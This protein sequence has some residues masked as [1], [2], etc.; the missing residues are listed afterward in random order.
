MEVNDYQIFLS[1]ASKI[2]LAL[3]TIL[4]LKGFFIQKKTFKIFN[5]YLFVCL[6]IQVKSYL[7][8]QD[9][10]D[11]LYLS[12][13]YFIS[14]FILLSLFYIT[15][16]NSKKHK[17]VVKIISLLVLLI[18]AIQYYLKPS[19]YYK[20]NLLEIVL[21]SLSIVSFSVVHF[22]NSLTEKTKYIYINSGIFVY[23]TCSTLIFCSGNFFKEGTG[24]LKNIL[25]LL[26]TILYVVYLIFI[27]IEWYKNYRKT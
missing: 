5:L 16:F 20:F 21:T 24:N 15:L 2:L 27:F 11:N 14:Q 3:N 12:H 6:I 1:N 26:N 19:L 22:Y 23:L 10:I 17:N 8:W 13:Y 18:L 25:W 4:F 9:K 7:L